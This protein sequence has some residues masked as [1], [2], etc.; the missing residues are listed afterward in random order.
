MNSLLKTIGLCFIMSVIA[1]GQT[2]STSLAASYSG[3]PM[4]T[5]IPVQDPAAPP[6]PPAPV[7]SANPEDF[8]RVIERVVHGNNKHL[9]VTT[10][11]EVDDRSSIRIEFDPSRMLPPAPLVL[12]GPAQ[13]RVTIRIEVTAVRTASQN[14]VAPI[15]NYVE[16]VSVPPPA[17]GPAGAPAAT[18]IHYH[19]RS[20]NPAINS[21]VPN[22]EFDLRALGISDADEIVVSIRNIENANVLLLHLYPRQFGLRPKASDTLMFVK[23][24][25]VSKADVAN[26]IS[27]FNFGPSPGVTYGGTFYARKNPF[28]RF[29]E[30]GIGITVL[31][32]KWDSQAFDVA[33]GQFVPGTKSSDI[34]T[35]V[36][37]QVSFFSGVV[38]VG[39]G[40]NLQVDQKRQYFSLG[41]SFVNLTTKISG[42]LSH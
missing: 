41:L 9:D 11:S 33:T 21:V 14:P 12:G 18:S 34:Q 30:P 19:D 6:A 15:L 42:L 3:A 26:G 17:A 1:W 27:T 35:A 39:Y 38:Q 10:N 31:F 29:L 23:R 7:Q 2:K 8:T 22:T 40:A 4:V 20:Y 25:G 37:G 13:P 24:L 5:A 36:G 32:T 16:S 28:L